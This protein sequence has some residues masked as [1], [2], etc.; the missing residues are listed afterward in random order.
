MIHQK[1]GQVMGGVIWL[2]AKHLSLST[3]VG[4]LLLSMVIAA[5]WFLCLNVEPSVPLGLWRLQPVPTVLTR[6]M[7]VYYDAPEAAWP[8]HHWWIPFLKPVAAVEGEVVCV[9]E[10]GL[11]VDDEWYGPVVAQAGGRALP[12]I[13]G[14]LTIQLGEVF[15]ASRTARTHDSRYY[16][17]VKVAD[18]KKMATPIWTWR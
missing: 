10:E 16:G 5:H 12:H 18:I 1:D 9:D 3:L 2:L 13:E 14:C 8:W 15:V 7:V 17:P 6:G 11:W 4:A